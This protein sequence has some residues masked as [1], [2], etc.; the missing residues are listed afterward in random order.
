MATRELGMPGSSPN[1]GSIAQEDKD[2]A[3]RR[4]S[5]SWQQGA[6]AIAISGARNG[7][8]GIWDAIDGESEERSGRDVAGGNGAEAGGP[9]HYDDV[10]T[11]TGEPAQT[12]VPAPPR[13]RRSFAERK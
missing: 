9:K 2:S 4:I 1:I 12:A 11:V 13:G 5:R 7:A 6:G 3:R 10:V 8:S